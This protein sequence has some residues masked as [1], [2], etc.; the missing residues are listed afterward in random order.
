MCYTIQGNVENRSDVGH[1]DWMSQRRITIRRF[2]MMSNY[3]TTKTII[4]IKSILRNLST[5]YGC[6]FDW[7]SFPSMI[8]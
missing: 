2:F 7:K 4:F 6:H 5:T 8:D 3:I 1:R